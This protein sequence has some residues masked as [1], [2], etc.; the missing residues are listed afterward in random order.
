MWCFLAVE[1]DA[2]NYLCCIVIFLHDNSW[3]S[4]CPLKMRVVISAVN[5]SVLTGLYPP[6]Q[7][8]ALIYGQD[9]R[10]DIDEIRQDMGMC[11]QHNVLFDRQ[12][13]LSI[14]L[15]EFCSILSMIVMCV[16]V[17]QPALQPT[18]AN[19]LQLYLVTDI[20]MYV[21]TSMLLALWV[22]GLY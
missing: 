8:T 20:I 14:S 16:C 22:L 15:V 19:N 10:F 6:T 13:L 17:K 11:P 1:A 21:N 2:A 4:A 12:E 5:S 18:P 7:G 3:H 9:V